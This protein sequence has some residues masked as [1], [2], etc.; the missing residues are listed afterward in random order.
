MS[1]FLFL[2]D[3]SLGLCLIV[4]VAKAN[5]QKGKKLDELQMKSFFAPE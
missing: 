5:L 3:C 1:Q 4:N 2:A